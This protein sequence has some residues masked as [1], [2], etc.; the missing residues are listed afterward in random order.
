MFSSLTGDQMPIEHV[1]THV[2]R[3]HWHHVHLYISKDRSSNNANLCT[4]RMHA[5]KDILAL[6]SLAHCHHGCHGSCIDWI[7]CVRF[8][9][10]MC[11]A[12]STAMW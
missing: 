6:E 11:N 3:Y 1:D 5:G 10:F 2:P 9:Y 4:Y 7:K 8:F 12:G